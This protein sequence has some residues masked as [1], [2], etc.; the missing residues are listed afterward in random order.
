MTTQE[1]L[2]Q[3]TVEGNNV[4]L[5]DVQLDRDLYLD[6]KKSLELIGGKWTGGKTQ[7]FVFE[8]DPAE[9]LQQLA[10]GEQRNL[11]KEFQFF[12]TP[13]EVA[14]LM[15]SKLA[16]DIKPGIKILEPSAGDGALIKAV[17]GFVSFPVEFD[18]YELMDLNR[19]KLQKIKGATL[20]GNDFLKQCRVENYYD[21]IIANPPFSYNQDILHFA[22]M[23][24]AL[25]PGGAM[26]CLTS[27]S[28]TF[29]SKAMQIAFKSWLHI[30]AAEITEIPAGE[31]KSS[32]TAVGVQ[33][34]TVYKR[35]RDAAE[36]PPSIL[37]KI[38]D[39]CKDEKPEQ[40]DK[41]PEPLSQTDIMVFLRKYEGYSFYDGGKFSDGK[42]QLFIHPDYVTDPA[43]VE[44]VHIIYYDYTG[45]KVI[46]EKIWE[47]RKWV[48]SLRRCRVCRC[49]E[50]NCKQCIDAT[51][52][53]CSWIE[54]DLCSACSDHQLKEPS[55]YINE[56]KNDE[57][58]Q[59]D[60]SGGRQKIEKIVKAADEVL[61]KETQVRRSH[62]PID[63][64]NCFF[65][66]Q[67][68]NE[69]LVFSKNE[70]ME[71]FHT[72]M[73][74]HLSDEGLNN[75]L[76]WAKEAVDKNGVSSDDADLKEPSHY[77]NEIKKLDAEVN[78]GMQE[79]EKMLSPQ[80][81]NEMSF[82]KTLAE[83]G[84]VDITIRIMQK[85]DKLTC[86]VFAGSHY[87]AVKPML[88]TGTGTELDENFFPTIYPKVQEITGIVSNLDE[89]KAEAEEKAAEE[90]DTTS[91]KKS[92]GK[93]KQADKNKTVKPAAAKPMNEQKPEKKSKT[94]EP[95]A[96]FA[97]AQA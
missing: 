78:S 83:Q 32:G 67:G 95:P 10:N 4:K 63:Y 30:L 14:L 62:F 87:S 97:E 93:S 8:Q 76:K 16:A 54:E 79:L 58:I 2:K 21:V 65:K 31:F 92:N 36:V 71:P 81:N 11:K 33:M 5:P 85:N 90:S 29:G 59:Q 42:L 88:I 56:I 23:Y 48:D 80:N 94:A 52:R 47:A 15:A 26:C 91:T 12:A 84:D 68:K 18:C 22:K 40:G 27:N 46:N 13:K 6:V 20:L 7:A 28:W 34:I 24:E 69:L 38:T 44:P 41:Q 64:K 17:Q 75:A 19:T 82:F 72:I 35:F 55:H 89:V 96:M 77:I 1:I 25:K 53:P 51:G 66:L 43:S 57:S 39:A 70:K 61:S 86:Q 60:V 73:F 9:L 37:R 45:P 3:C 74:D 50:H 49:T